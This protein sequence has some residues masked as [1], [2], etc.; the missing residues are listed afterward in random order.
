[1]VRGAPRED[2][3]APVDLSDLLAEGA[4]AEFESALVLERYG[5]EVAPRR[6]AVT[7][8]EAAAAAAELGFPVVVK[9]DGPAH[10][11]A[12]GG[13]VLGLHDEETVAAAAERLGG[14]VLVARQTEAGLEAFC[15]VTRDEL[16]GPVLAV[17]PGGRNVEALA[18][19]AV[20]LAPVGLDGALALVA[21]VPTLADAPGPARETLART[22]VALGRLAGEHPDVAAVDVNPLILGEDGAVAVDAL[23]VVDRGGAG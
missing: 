11:Q 10:K 9:V 22:L 15:G 3:A 5:V 8:D 18:V 1:V 14:R 7:P 23:V 20:T 6:R 21:D 19:A 16:Y 2:D 4:L 12:A 13:V 17:G